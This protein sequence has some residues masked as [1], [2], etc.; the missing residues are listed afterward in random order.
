MGIFRQF[1]YS[2]FHEM[3]MDEIIKIMKQ[4]QEEWND[5]KSEWASYKDFIDNYFANLNVSEEVLHAIQAMADS[6]ELN[7]VIDPVIITETTNWLAAN[8]TPTTPAVDKT[9]AISGAAADSKVTG[10]GFKEN[11]FKFDEI[12]KDNV[13]FGTTDYTETTVLSTWT[14]GEPKRFALPEEAAYLYFHWDSVEC[15]SGTPPTNK[16]LL[17]FFNGAEQIGS[18]I[19]ANISGASYTV[20]EGAT[21]ITITFYTN[22]TPALNTY[23]KYVNFYLTYTPREIKAV[24]KNTVYIDDMNMDEVAEILKDST[25]I[26]VTESRNIFKSEFKQG[27]ISSTGNYG[28]IT[29]IHNTATEE[30]IEVEPNTGYTLSWNWNRYLVTLYLYEYKADKSYIGARTIDSFVKRISYKNFTTGADTHYIR[31]MCYTPDNTS[32]DQISNL[33][34]QLIRGGIPYNKINTDNVNNMVDYE[35]IRN[36]KLNI[37]DYYFTNNYLQNKVDTIKNLMFDA[38][39]NYDAFVFITDTHW[40]INAQKSPA[41]IRYIKKALN[42]NKIFHGGDV[43]DVWSQFWHNDCLDLLTDAF[44]KYPMTVAGNHEYKN[45]MNDNTIWYFLNSVHDNIT[46]GSSARNY[47]YYDNKAQKIRYIMLNMYSDA[48]NDA[49][50]DF[51]ATQQDWLI[52]TA[53]DIPTDYN[54][55]IITH[56]MYECN[57]TNFELVPITNV[58]DTLNN[59]IDT[60]NND[61]TKGKILALIQGHLH[62]DRITS[63]PGG[64]PVIVTTCDKNGIWIDP[65][66]GLGDLRYCNRDTGTINEQAFDVYV[67]DRYNNKITAVR[68]GAEAFDGV[69]NNMGVQVPLRTINI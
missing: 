2:N 11:K 16:V 44:E 35:E 36:P 29:G 47:Y 3:N 5:T 51:D 32:Y 21:H 27:S 40:E 31:F 15:S 38:H 56:T 58:T 34:A 54:A 64:T 39:G 26:D 45:Q 53:L 22:N 62:I 7:T 8:I 1:P 6:G 13:I 49:Q 68:I 24:L 20:P 28:P 12:I 52:N 23:I 30:M 9:L 10:D 61:D 65:V 19:Y 4:L 69:G 46:V 33:N 18:N 55:I 63:T 14:S 37:P 57:I 59:I 42:I 41:L 66:T 60:H 67:V 43:F 48:G 50:I 25:V 17:K